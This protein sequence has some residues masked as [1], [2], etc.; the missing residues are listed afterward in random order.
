MTARRSKKL[1]MQLTNSTLCAYSIHAL[2]LPSLLSPWDSVD[3]DISE[4]TSLY[5]SDTVDE[6]GRDSW[7]GVGTK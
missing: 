1:C 5:L 4:A 7:D 2:V 6:N 3:A